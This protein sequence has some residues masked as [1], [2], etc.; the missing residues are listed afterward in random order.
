VL[1]LK[2]IF[3]LEY[4]FKFERI[5]YFNTTLHTNKL[6]ILENSIN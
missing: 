1:V 3:N 4:S 2:F 5:Q 6:I